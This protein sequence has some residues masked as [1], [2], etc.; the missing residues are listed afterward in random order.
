VTRI[1]KCLGEVGLEH[2][3]LPF[4]RHIVNEIKHGSLREV[5][6]SA[7]KYWFPV[8]RNEDDR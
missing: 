3:K 2:Y 7:E 1:L 8:L 5:A 6:D 4:C